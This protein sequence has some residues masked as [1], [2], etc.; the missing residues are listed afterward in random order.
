M[1]D[2]FNSQKCYTSP[3]AYWTIQYEYKREGADMYYRFYWKVWL[4]YSTSYYDWGIALR[5]YLDGTSHSV[6]VKNQNV[7]EYGWTKSGTTEWYKVA[8]KSTG[9]TSFYA[10]LYDTSRSKA[11]CTSSTYSLTVSPAASTLG[12][13]Q[14]FNV[15]DGISIP[16]TKYD[17]T[18]TDTLVVSY[19][20][21]NIYTLAD[22]KQGTV[23]RFSSDQLATI[24]RL[25][26]TVKSGTF[27]FTLTTK[28]G[29]TTLGSSVKTATGSITHA[30][31][32]FTANQVTYADTNATVVGITGNNQHIVQNKSSLT[33]YLDSATGNKGASISKYDVTV[34]GVT[35]TATAKGSIVFG[36]INTS[37]NTTITV[38]V[39]DSR[40][41]T[42][43][44]SKNAT[45]LAYA[46]PTFSA[47][48]ERLNNYEDTTYVTVDASISSVNNKNTLTITYKIK[49]SGGSYGTAT[50]LT[51][52]TRHTVNCD[53]NYVYVFSITASDKFESAT[54]EIPL[55]KGKFPLFIDTEKNAVGI[56]EFPSSDEA[57]VVTGGL[58]T[59]H[60]G[61]KAIMLTSA[62]NLDNIK[63]NGWYQWD[64]DHPPVNAP[65]DT[66]TQYMRSMRVWAGKY[67]ECC[68]EVI[69]LS[70]SPRHGCMVRRTIY[71]DIVYPWEWVNPPM[72]LG[73]EYRTTERFATSPIYKKALSLGYISSGG[74]LTV[75]HNIPT[76][77]Y[78]IECKLFDSIGT[79]VGAA[80]FARFTTSSVTVT[81]PSGVSGLGGYTIYAMLSYTASR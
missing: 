81:L 36:T 12:T 65:S 10:Q 44:V 6:T 39:T 67:G 68:Q 56:N 7:N 32:T 11:M 38:K 22:A 35:K 16:I 62:D 75:S 58:A 72:A 80:T 29:S 37:Q 1:I 19:G 13:I 31:P 79:I 42:T 24:Y 54:K 74:T 30:N 27:T 45:I 2:I 8:N 63:T 60:D 64:W 76:I 46:T 26:S 61:I 78:P 3:N 34:N 43:T 71:N 49:Q 25:M 28:S 41:N 18:Y 77:A 69:D 14:N 73:V 17:T 47:T 23:V 50:T 5:F 66:G 55:P 15:G 9:T 57:L 20:G 48:V 33:V 4:A 59:F 70:D 52:K 21:T 51:N 40:G 53:K